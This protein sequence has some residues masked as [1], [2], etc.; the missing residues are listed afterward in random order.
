MNNELIALI[1]NLALTLSFIIA[2]IFGIVQVKTS[3]RDRQERLTLEALRTFQS[4]EFAE[5]IL[6]VTTR[7]MPANLKE[8]NA[9]PMGERAMYVQFGQEME[10]V[11]ILVAERL[12]SL[13]LV[14]KTLGSLVITSWAKYQPIFMDMREK[15]PDPFL[16]EYFQWLAEQIERRMN[17]HPRKPF[18]ETGTRHAARLR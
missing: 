2:L 10:S 3:K 8:W 15:Q 12:I 11:G 18:F 7:N 14:D 16:G 5:L 9:M 13:D 4:R 1:A 17:E 6:H